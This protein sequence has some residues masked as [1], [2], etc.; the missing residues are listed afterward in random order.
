MANAAHTGVTT[1]DAPAAVGITCPPAKTYADAGALVETKKYAEAKRVLNDLVVCK[2]K[3]GG[4]A[5]LDEASMADNYNLLGF[6]NR[7]Q[8]S[9][10]VAG[11]V[12]SL[13]P[14]SGQMVHFLVHSSVHWSIHS[15]TL[16]TKVIKQP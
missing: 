4:G 10:D 11:S 6:T 9:P 3:S 2:H 7:K 16:T 1:L 8:A 15:Y 5:S 14:Q 13:T 12:Y